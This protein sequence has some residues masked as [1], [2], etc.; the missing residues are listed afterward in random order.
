MEARALGTAGL[1]AHERRCAYLFRG[2]ELAPPEEIAQVEVPWAPPSTKAAQEDHL[3]LQRP[4]EA[5]HALEETC[6]KG[7]KVIGCDEAHVGLFQL[8][9]PYLLARATQA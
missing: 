8:L 1:A 3:V 2:H 5:D 4:A 6:R 9:H 7:S